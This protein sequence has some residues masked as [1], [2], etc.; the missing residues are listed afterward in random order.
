MDIL[1]QQDGRISTNF[2]IPRDR[3]MYYRT[4]EAC[5]WSA[6]S[7]MMKGNDIPSPPPMIHR[8]FRR[9]GTEGDITVWVETR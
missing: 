4:V 6:L 3:G 1:I 7:G 5:G 8:T 9:L 2:I